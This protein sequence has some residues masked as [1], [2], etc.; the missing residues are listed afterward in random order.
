MQE[1]KITPEVT[2]S[3]ASS[4]TDSEAMTKSAHR[5]SRATSETSS[6]VDE[7]KSDAGEMSMI[8]GV[9]RNFKRGGGIIS[10]F[11]SSAFFFG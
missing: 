8:S 9:A 2:V 11:F 3:T 10:T 5:E 1:K 7:T 6:F 4:R